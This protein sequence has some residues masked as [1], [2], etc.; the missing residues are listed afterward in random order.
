MARQKAKAREERGG[1][2]G[3]E[4]FVLEKTYTSYAVV[5]PHGD[6]EALGVDGRLAVKKR[7]N[8]LI[9]EADYFEFDWSEPGEAYLYLRLHVDD[10]T[11]ERHALVQTV[12]DEEITKAHEAAPASPGI[13]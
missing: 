4:R 6:N 8:E 10:D 2:A 7:L 3:P 12:L 9:P 11:P 1:S 13:R 5:I